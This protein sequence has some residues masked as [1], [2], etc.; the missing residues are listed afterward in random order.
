MIM[1]SKPL[2]ALAICAGMAALTQWEAYWTSD[3][4]NFMLLC[5]LTVVHIIVSGLVLWLIPGGRLF[6]IVVIDF[7]IVG[8]WWGIEFI[9]MLTIWYLRG[10]AP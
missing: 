9:A 10:F 1:T 4:N 2:M 6:K 3:N 5:V 7:L 8:Q